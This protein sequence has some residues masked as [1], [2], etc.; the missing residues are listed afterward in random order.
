MT[1]IITNSKLSD[2]PDLKGIA[3]LQGNAYVFNIYSENNV[4]TTYTKTGNVISDIIYDGTASTPCLYRIESEKFAHN[5]N[6]A[7]AKGDINKYYSQGGV[8]KV[9][10]E[11]DADM[12]FVDELNM[13]TAVGII[14]KDMKGR[15]VVLGEKNG[16]T[17]QPEEQFA[18]GQEEG[19]DVGTTITLAGAEYVQYSLFFDTDEATTEAKLIALEATAP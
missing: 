10:Q 6:Y 18:A 14:Y 3:G 15:W 13:A 1:C 7:L 8:I 9:L 19:A 4:Q 16:L 5:F 2:C 12:T 11:T 17:A